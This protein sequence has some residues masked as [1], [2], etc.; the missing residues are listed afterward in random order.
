[1]AASCL[2]DG[3]GGRAS[4]RSAAMPLETGR[5]EVCPVARRAGWCMA[6]LRYGSGTG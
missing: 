1:M 4:T 2:T 6:R 3:P 5:E